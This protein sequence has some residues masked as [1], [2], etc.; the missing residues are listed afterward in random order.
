MYH[1]L[2]RQP[3]AVVDGGVVV[4]AYEWKFL[5]NRF[6]YYASG[7]E[8]VIKHMNEMGGVGW[9]GVS[10]MIERCEA[11]DKAR[12]EKNTVLGRRGRKEQR[13]IRLALGFPDEADE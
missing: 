3:S 9:K 2:A 7:R 11:G 13:N 5:N 1:I 10:A 8:T 12:E 6:L 4:P